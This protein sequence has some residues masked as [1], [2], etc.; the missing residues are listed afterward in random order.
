MTC[1]RKAVLIQRW[2]R[3][4]LE[5]RR[6]RRALNAAVVLQC[7]VRCWRARKELKSLRTEARS[8]E[9]LQKLNVGMENKIIQLQHRINEQVGAI[10]RSIGCSGIHQSCWCGR[11][12]GSLGVVTSHEQHMCPPPP[13]PPTPLPLQ[14]Q[15]IG[16]LSKLL[17]LREALLS[18]ERDANTRKTLESEQEAREKEEKI[19][20]LSEQ[21]SLLQQQ[22]DG[23]QRDKAD[24]EEQMKVYKEETQQVD[25]FF[26][27]FYFF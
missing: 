1:E 12:I 25:P 22:L 19:G 9:H 14:H 27:K 18:S 23:S 6:Y 11:Q 15:E 8:V 26:L 3:G 10:V 17:C 20:S 16:E 5:R 24:L 7:C 13:P 21:L 4:W 2:V